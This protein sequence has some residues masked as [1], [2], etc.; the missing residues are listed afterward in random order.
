MPESRLKSEVFP[1]PFGPMIPSSS[2]SRTSRPTSATI[3]APPM[4]S[5]R[6]RVARTVALTRLLERADRRLQVPRRE[7]LH[8][9]GLP[10][11]SALAQAH[12]EHGLEQ[13]VILLADPVDPL[14][15][16][17]LPALEGGD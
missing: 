9:H 1:A 8:R 3:V 15:A 5:P 4:S 13:R 16:D 2:P 7:R 10:A 17:E 6:P 11:A 12:L 14:R